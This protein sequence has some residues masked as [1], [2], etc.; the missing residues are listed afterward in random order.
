MVYGVPFAKRISSASCL[1]ERSAA[2]A[3]RKIVY[4]ARG[5][6]HFEN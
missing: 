1:Q 6:T 3:V 4:H 2:D 5:M